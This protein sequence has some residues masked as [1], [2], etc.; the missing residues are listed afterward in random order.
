MIDNDAA[1]SIATSTSRSSVGTT[2]K[3]FKCY[4]KC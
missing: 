1:H 4:W 2:L 3:I